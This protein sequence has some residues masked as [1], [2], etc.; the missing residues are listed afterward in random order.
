MTN[1]NWMVEELMSFMIGQTDT[2]CPF[3]ISCV[4][5][6]TVCVCYSSFVFVDMTFFLW[7][8]M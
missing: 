7:W 8:I 1:Q 6:A 4:G 5:V 3:F 2:I